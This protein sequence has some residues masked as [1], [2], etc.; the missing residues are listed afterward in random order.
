[1]FQFCPPLEYFVKNHHATE[2]LIDLYR[3]SR[4]LYGMR[5]VVAG[6]SK[7]H[8]LTTEELAQ[9]ERLLTEL[10]L[11]LP[12]KATGFEYAPWQV[13]DHQRQAKALEAK[14]N[15]SQPSTEE[16]RRMLRRVADIIVFLGQVSLPAYSST[17]VH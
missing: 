17:R 4:E 3:G 2:R 7:P 16:T 15:L 11:E 5:K 12:H 8:K 9:V 13:K 1:M 6:G 14:L 10:E